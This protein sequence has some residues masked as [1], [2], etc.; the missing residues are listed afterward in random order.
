MSWANCLN[1]KCV[2]DPKNP[3]KSICKCVVATG[4]IVTYNDKK[5]ESVSGA[6]LDSFLQTVQYWNSC[7]G[8]N[9]LKINQDAYLK[10]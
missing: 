7:A 10:K 2:V 4:S 8:V 1:Q 5:L 6:S 3:K 9:I